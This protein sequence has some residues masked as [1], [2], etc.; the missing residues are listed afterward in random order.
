MA[1]ETDVKTEADD[2]P[3]YKALMDRM[4]DPCPRTLRV[5]DKELKRRAVRNSAGI[6]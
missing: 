2:S 6:E 5:W 3:F 1:S 4:L